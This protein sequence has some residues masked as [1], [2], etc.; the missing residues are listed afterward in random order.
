MVVGGGAML[1]LVWK[2]AL[3]S[4][5]C[6]RRM[7]AVE[8][9]WLVVVGGQYIVSLSLSTLLPTIYT[10]IPHLSYSSPH[11]LW[12]DKGRH[13]MCRHVSW[14]VQSWVVEDFC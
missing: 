2:L 10:L 11:S 1:A 12:Y 7:F 6:C 3:G 13:R 14:R 5:G 9:G 4:T 8:S